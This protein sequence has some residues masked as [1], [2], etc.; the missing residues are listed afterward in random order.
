MTK[1]YDIKILYDKEKNSGKSYKNIVNILNTKVVPFT[2]FPHND[3]RGH[4][5]YVYL[6]KED[7]GKYNCYSY[8][9]IRTNILN[10]ERFMNELNEIKLKYNLDSN[11]FS[12]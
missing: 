1:L 11:P 6:K 10:L 2:T 7:N 12:E 9:E 4:G 3:V 8:R 5:P